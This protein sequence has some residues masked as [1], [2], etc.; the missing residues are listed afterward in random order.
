MSGKEPESLLFDR[1]STERR[2][3]EATEDGIDPEIWFE[4]RRRVLRLK[5]SPTEEGSSPEIALWEAVSVARLRA[6][7]RHSGR[8][9]EKLLKSTWTQRRDGKLHNRL[10]SPMRLF[11][12]KPLYKYSDKQSRKQRESAYIAKS[13]FRLPRD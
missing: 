8:G 2:G 11:W 13:F 7:E 1:S 3:S 6:L 5:R 12:R 4:P 9:P 10:K